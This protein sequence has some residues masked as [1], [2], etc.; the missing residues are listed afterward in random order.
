MGRFAVLALAGLSVSIVAAVAQ[1]AAP[2]PETAD[3]QRPVTGAQAQTACF[4]LATPSPST[5]TLGVHMVMVNRCTG[6][7]WALVK[8]FGV[9]PKKGEPP[10]YVFRWFPL[11]AQEQEATLAGPSAKDIKAQID[12]LTKP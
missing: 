5:V 1:E 9:S 7:S 4:E 3:D 12:A 8:V 2:K 10:N 6:A 11:S